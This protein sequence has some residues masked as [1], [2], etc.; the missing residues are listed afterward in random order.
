MKFTTG[1]LTGILLC[2]I[3]PI[4][5]QAGV[6]GEVDVEEKE[7][8][9]RPLITAVPEYPTKAYRQRREATVVICF[10]IDRKGRVRK[11]YVFT[12][13]SRAFERAAMKAIRASRYEPLHPSQPQEDVEMCRTYRF[14]LE[15]QKP[16]GQ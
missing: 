7:I 8:D 6:N 10:V 5:S 9:R 16:A 3:A 15:P 4:A 11:P 1:L 12:H 2:G 13:S 14:R